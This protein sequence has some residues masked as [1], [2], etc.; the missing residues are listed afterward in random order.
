MKK[1]NVLKLKN[2][3]IQELSQTELSELRGGN[4]VTVGIKYVWDYVLCKYVVEPIL[5][6]VADNANYNPPSGSYNPSTD[7]NIYGYTCPSDNA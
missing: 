5:V 1:L 4:W 2:Q 7:P 6:W 3:G